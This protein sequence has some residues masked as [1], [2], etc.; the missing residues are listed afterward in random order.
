VNWINAARGR[1]EWPILTNLPTTLNVEHF[2]SFWII[3]G[4]SIRID[5]KCLNVLENSGR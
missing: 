3:I 5:C 1:G 4:L 2:L